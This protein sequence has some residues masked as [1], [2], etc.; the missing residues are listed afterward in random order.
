M[1]L[2]AM[3]LLFAAAQNSAKL[4][5][6]FVIFFV[7][8]LLLG[9]AMFVFLSFTQM[10]DNGQANAAHEDNHQEEDSLKV[11][12]T[13]FVHKEKDIKYSDLLPKTSDSFPQYTE[14]LLSKMAQELHFVQALLYIKDVN[15]EV[16]SC[17]A[18]YA[19]FSNENPA[20]FSAGESIPGQAIKNK[21]IV[22]LSHIPESYLTIASGLGKGSPAELVFIPLSYNHQ[23]IGLIEYA[24]FETLKNSQKEEFE[25]LAEEAS[26][27]IVKLQ[28]K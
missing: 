13:E 7:L 3:F 12:E 23:I 24:S 11:E 22:T 18:K 25:K 15:T 10:Q 17:M 21:A 6:W 14:D 4:S 27:V 19:Y 16:F 1:F 5:A 9:S 2:L 8:T 26:K 28:K 20:S